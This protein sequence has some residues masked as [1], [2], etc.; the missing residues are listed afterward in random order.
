MNIQKVKRLLFFSGVVTFLGALSLIFVVGAH[1]I[2]SV[3]DNRVLNDLPMILFLLTLCV[4]VVGI[5][6]SLCF[7]LLTALKTLETLIIE[8]QSAALAQGESLP[9]ED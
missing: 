2:M 9:E 1:I 3:V 5:V 4:G 6:G 7:G 8:S